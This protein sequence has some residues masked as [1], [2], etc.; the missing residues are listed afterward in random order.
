MSRFG[1]LRRKQ[2]RAKL[3]RKIPW[4]LTPETARCL[5]ASMTEQQRMLSEIPAF[6]GLF[7]APLFISV[8]SKPG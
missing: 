1:V 5:H 2:R 8:S 3:M 4:L 7:D 6:Y